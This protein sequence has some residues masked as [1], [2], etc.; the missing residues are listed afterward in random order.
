MFNQSYRFKRIML[1]LFILGAA[2]FII[3]GCKPKAEVVRVES[4]SISAA[5]S[6]TTITTIG[7][8]LQFSAVVLPTDANDKAVTWSVQN[9]TG[10]GTITQNGLLTAVSDGTVTVKAIAKDNSAM[11]ATKV[12]TISNQSVVANS[13]SVSSEA[14]KAFIDVYHGTLQMNALVLPEN[15]VNKAVIWTVENGTGSAS[16][17][18]SGLLTAIS[19]GIVT[20]KATSVN[21]T[22]VFGTKVITLT[23]QIVVA[24]T[25]TVSGL[26]AASS[27]DVFEGTLQM[28]AVVLPAN[29]A[30]KRVVWSVVNGTGAASISATGLLTAMSNGTVTVKA[31]S[32]VNALVY[33]TKVITI[34]HQEVLV[35][36]IVLA[37]ANDA[38]VIET[39]A[40]T[41]QFSAN[42]LPANAFN[43]AVVWSIENGT[44]Q[45]TISNNG[46]VTAVENGLVTVVVTSVSDP[47]IKASMVITISHQEVLVN[48]ISVNGHNSVIIIDTLAGTLQMEAIVLPINAANKNIIWSVVSGT[49]SASISAS[50]LLT[51]I[52]DGTVIVKATSVENPLLFGTRTITISHQEVLVASIVLTSAND[53]IVIETLAGT[54]QFSANVL[55]E[56]AFNKA[57]V[58]SIE[59]GTGQATISNN[60]LVTA[61]ENGLVTVVVTSV[62]DPLIKATMVITISHQE[63][64]V[65]SISVNGADD[66]VIID[67]FGGTLQMMAIVLPNDAYNQDV[68][69]SVVNGTGSASISESGLL[70]AI[71][72]GTVTVQA[73]SEE[74]PLIYGT[75]TITI[76]N[77]MIVVTDIS[78]SSHLDAIVIE[79][80]GGTLQFTASIMPIDADNQQVI[81]SIVNGT[82]SASIDE[83]GLVTALSNGT[84]TVKAISESNPLIQDTM[85][86]TISH[87]E[88]LVSAIE[89]NSADQA[90]IIDT[91]GGTLQ[92]SSIVLPE[93]AEDKSVIWSI[94][95]GTGEATID[96]NGLVTAVSD[97]TVLVVVTSVNSPGVE[98]FME[99]TIS[100]QV[101]VPEP[102]APVELLTAG[103]F[104]ILSKTGISTAANSLIV[105]NIGV[106]PVAA[107]YITG[108]SLMLDASNNYAISTQVVGMVYAADYA[109][110]TPAYVTQAISD[111]E[112]AYT[113]AASRAPDFT[114]LYA[115][116]LSGQTLV[117]GVYKYSTDVVIYA[118]VIL[119]GNAQDVWIFQISGNL[120]QAVSVKIILQGGALAENVFWQIAGNVAIETSA[121]FV[122]TIIAMTEI[123]LGTNAS[124]TGKLL[125]QTAVTLDA[126]IISPIEVIDPM[127]LVITAE[128]DAITI[129]TFNGT[130]QMVSTFMPANTTNKAVIWTVENNTGAAIISET[131]LL[132]ARD[133]GLV[134]VK[135]TS[136]VNPLIFDTYEVTLSN[137]DIL[138]VSITVEAQN[139]DAFIDVQDGVLQMFAHVLPIDADDQLYTWSVENGT[140]EATITVQGVLIASANGTVT[141]KAS[142]NSDPLIFGVLDVIITN[143]EPIVVV[144]G[145]DL[146]TAADFVIL[147]K[148]GISATLGT[149]IVGNIGVS[150][151]PASYITGFGLIV[152]AGLEYST[153]TLVTGEIYASDYAA[154]TPTYVATAILDM[155]AAYLDAASKIPDFTELYAG[156]ISGQNLE[157]GVYYWSSGLLITTNLILTGDASDIWIFQIAGTLTVGVDVI[158]TLE[159]GALAE[160]VFWQVAS[161]VT[162]GVGSHFEGTIL[163]M[164]SVI[165]G[166]GATLNGRIFA[167]TAVTLDA[168]LIN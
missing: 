155:E 164:T 43:K 55:P 167:Q 117:G 81:W 50:G 111:M 86:I 108:F 104:T 85:V 31:T 64:L 33:G 118:D 9:G 17:S 145:I 121:H 8:T 46:L 152:D 30:D 36:S 77:Q 126:N 122:G 137:Q 89:I 139:G 62:S 18:T 22:T 56:N 80:F 13:I 27:I 29:T 161:A 136:A 67:T 12:I 42:V 144:G 130:L 163:G 44:G 133:N 2:L 3:S 69:W 84:I 65:N 14:E 142:L 120:T 32:M 52:E 26:D 100:N 151:G 4:V 58:W 1:S 19:D 60:G 147:S 138:A 132:E 154:P 57:V 106:S 11:F 123:S 75:R 66:K 79:T 40:G 93:N 28:G 24:N 166:T 105:G 74:N 168:N 45:A 53:A 102:A 107:T 141:V 6:A 90:V 37:S 94:E 5:G 97:G 35:A 124:V 143:Q 7:G 70:T 98:A 110:P 92:F 47:L 82:G 25:I 71:E 112:A 78:I 87:Q 49:G 153:S 10:S 34:T 83:N 114:E 61:V 150:P 116:D 115:G 156:D 159:G 113:D 88:V 48:S 128:L 63:V 39:F 101:F 73:T 20:V 76:S 157:A 16:I 160:N 96:Q 148:T 165:V 129:D 146:K 135:A 119:S 54:L 125:S 41:L 51:A 72:D 91:L 59:N 149:H 140:G 162:L 103:H 23:N 38:I 15:T 68:I 131:G 99:I 158:V 134:T 21:Q 95:N 109:D 127:G